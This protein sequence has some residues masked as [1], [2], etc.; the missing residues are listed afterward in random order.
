MTETLDKMTEGIAAAVDRRRFLR[1]TANATFVM[2]ATIAAGGVLD[3]LRPEAAWAHTGCASAKGLGCP[4]NA[5][6]PHPCGT[7]RCCNYL[8]SGTP[9]SCNCRKS[10]STCKSNSDS[11]NCYGKDTRYYSDGC[12][13]CTGSCV[14]C[15]Y[16]YCRT[17]TT[18]CDCKTNASR[19]KDPDLGGN[20]G[21]CIAWS[22]VSSCC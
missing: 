16:C 8:R 20:R 19:C 3:V 9:S 15:Y 14:N 10:G 17:V 21:R 18:C 11:P 6:H 7:S 1:R 5:S 4:S 22:A 12:W 13:T 2:V